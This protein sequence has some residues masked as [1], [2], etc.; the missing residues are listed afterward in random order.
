MNY[1]RKR[2]AYKNQSAQIFLSGSVDKYRVLFIYIVL[3]E[4]S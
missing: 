4:L 2:S 3:Y 1:R